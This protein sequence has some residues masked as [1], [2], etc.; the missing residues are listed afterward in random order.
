[1]IYFMFYDRRLN[2]KY[3][4]RLQKIKSQQVQTKDQE[5]SMGSKQYVFHV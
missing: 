4:K 3:V 1:M 2:K 5:H